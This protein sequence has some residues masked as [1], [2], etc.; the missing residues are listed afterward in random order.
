MNTFYNNTKP[1]P[2]D[3]GKEPCRHCK[4]QGFNTK[5][6]IYILDLCRYCGG[7]SYIDWIDHMTGNPT[8]GKPDCDIRR[9]IAIQNVQLLMHEIKVI[10]LSEGICATVS[11]QGEDPPNLEPALNKFIMAEPMINKRYKKL[12]SI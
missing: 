1:A 9:N 3:K 11:I 6:A 4:G 12:L 10:L 5:K 8:P 2:L 7:R